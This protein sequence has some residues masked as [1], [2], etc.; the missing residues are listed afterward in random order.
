[1]IAHMTKAPTPPTTPPIMAP[2]F[3]DAAL[4]VSDG[5]LDGEAIP[6]LAART[7][8]SA[9]A[10]AVASVTLD[11][12]EL[13]EASKIVLVTGS[14]DGDVSETGGVSEGKGATE[15]LAIS[16]LLEDTIGEDAEAVVDSEVGSGKIATE[17][18][19]VLGISSGDI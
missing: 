8:D 9:V 2:R 18:V 5:L 13:V 15:P 3:D 17:V 16:E 10:P 7:E 19:V 12:S 4:A 11:A 14:V 6:L 1:M